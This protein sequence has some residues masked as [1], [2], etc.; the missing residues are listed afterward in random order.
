M[1][2]SPSS[3][4]IP[5]MDSEMFSEDLFPK[6]FFLKVDDAASGSGSENVFPALK[7]AQTSSNLL[8]PYLFVNFFFRVRKLQELTEKSLLKHE[9]FTNE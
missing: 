1:V 8:P 2:L 3:F 7:S 4:T 6:D 5:L 9:K